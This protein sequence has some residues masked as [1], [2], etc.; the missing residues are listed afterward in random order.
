MIPHSKPYITQV[1]I[2]SV[3]KRLSSGMISE[4]EEVDHFEREVSAYAGIKHCIATSSGVTALTL[5]LYALNVRSGDEIIIP[6]YLCISVAQAV[7]NFGAVPVL[8]DV[9]ETWCMTYE[10]VSKCLTSKTKAIILVHL[11]GINAWDERLKEFNIP[12]IE[13]NCQAFGHECDGHP[14]S[15]KGEIAFYSFHATKCLATGEGGML[16]TNTVQ[17]FEIA[18]GHKINH[19]PFCRMTDLQAA[20]GI[21]QIRQYDEMKRKR[22]YIAE[23]Y[24]ENLPQHLLVNASKIRN[25]SIFFRFPVTVSEKHAGDHIRRFAEKGIIVRKGVDS[26]VHRQFGIPDNEFQHTVNCFNT[27]LSLPIYPAL[28]ETEL[29]RVINHANE[30]FSA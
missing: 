10:S 30:I 5:S 26:L 4:G 8:C 14:F 21:S 6:S 18:K 28:S 20:L 27:T 19:N 23:R 24:F 16:A 3:S 13:D 9:S 22:K 2:F 25:R 12:I 1:D 17:Y 15:L 29:D 11:F 7:H